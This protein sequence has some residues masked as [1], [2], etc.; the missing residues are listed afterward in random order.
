MFCTDCTIVFQG[1]HLS[2][3]VNKYKVHHKRLGACSEVKEKEEKVWVLQLGFQQGRVERKL[4]RHQGNC[5]FVLVPEK[6]VNELYSEKKQPSWL[7]FQL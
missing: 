1:D 7:L 4:K 2:G 3:A 5:N 6:R